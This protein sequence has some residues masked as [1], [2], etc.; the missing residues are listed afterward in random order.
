MPLIDC[1]GVRYWR[2]WAEVRAA[3]CL[4]KVFSRSAFP[5]ISAPATCLPDS[6][7]EMTWLEND[8]FRLFPAFHEKVGAT[9]T[10]WWPSRCFCMS[11]DPNNTWAFGLSVW[12]VPHQRTVFV[13]L[14]S[15][16]DTWR[17]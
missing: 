2:L 15:D 4:W 1:T 7:M 14:L 9:D 12:P 13:S 16:S 8:M 6:C 11:M 17:S 3:H 10:S 5:L